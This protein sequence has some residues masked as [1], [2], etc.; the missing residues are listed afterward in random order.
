VTEL[1]TNAGALN[2]ATLPQGAMQ[3]RN[4]YGTQ[5]FGG[6]CP[7]K[8]DKPHHYIFT[9]YALKTDKLDVPADAS[10]AL[11]GFMIHAN[12]LGKARFVARYGRK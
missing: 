9:I 7:P 8:G 6:T 5:A 4:D 1:P 3:I 11:A 10:A 2:S 12:M